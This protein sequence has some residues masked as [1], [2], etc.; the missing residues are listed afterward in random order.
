MAG[1]GTVV[2][3]DGVPVRPGRLEAAELGAGDG[4]Q[5]GVLGV[6]QVEDPADMAAGDDQGVAGARREV[7]LEGDDVG[8][9]DQ[10]GPVVPGQDGPAE[11]AGV[12]HRRQTMK[13]LASGW[14]TTMADVD[15]SGWSWNSSDTVTPM[16]PISSSSATFT[17][18]SRSGQAG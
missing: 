18:S 7:V 2:D 15:C 3:A 5:V 8:G 9:L 12:G 11:E 6:G 4:E 10:Q 14:W 16:R 17:W 1:G 13:Y